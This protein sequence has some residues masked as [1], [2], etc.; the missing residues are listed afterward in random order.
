MN[1]DG[2]LLGRFGSTYDNDPEAKKLFPNCRDR[3][4]F[5]D[6]KIRIND[7]RKVEMKFTDFEDP[8]I[9]ILL[10]VRTFDLRNEKDLNENLFNNAWYRLQNE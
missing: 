3:T 4:N 7:D 8:T 6:E 10:M 2:Q 5:R 9:Q 1:Q